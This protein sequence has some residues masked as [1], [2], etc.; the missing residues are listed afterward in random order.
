MST[1]KWDLRHIICVI[2]LSLNFSFIQAQRIDPDT[3]SETKQNIDY[4]EVYSKKFS[5]VNPAIF[6]Y[7]T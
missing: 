1:Y 6:S 4:A 2:L 5:A 3:I 7:T